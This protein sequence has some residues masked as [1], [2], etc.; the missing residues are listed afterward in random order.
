MCGGTD[1]FRFDNKKGR[2]TF[3]CNQC[4]AGDGLDLIQKIKNI[5]FAEA[6]RMVDDLLQKHG[7]KP[8]QVHEPPAVSREEMERMWKAAS[9]LSLNNPGGVYIS[10]RTGIERF[11]KALRFHQGAMLA[12]VSDPS[13]RGIQIHKTMLDSNGNKLGRRML[14]APLP[15]G[16]A[17]RLYDPMN[18]VLG[19]AEGIETAISA[20]IL[21]NCP[22]WAL[23]NANNL[24]KWEPP[25]GVNHVIV[26][27]DNDNSFTGQ[28]ASFALAKKLARMDLFVDVKIPFTRGWDWNDVQM[29]GDNH[30]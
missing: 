13:G 7:Q 4:G 17:I 23:I 8:V 24:E 12:K 11:P 28:S 10:S 26:F 19:V 16:S 22:V 18:G 21:H 15:H 5:T 2:G 30:V 14:R 29:K 25:A 1:R 6:A 27:G 20:A 9:P 3:F